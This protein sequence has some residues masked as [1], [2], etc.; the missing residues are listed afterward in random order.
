MYN[1][2]GIFYELCV[3]GGVEIL[4]DDKEDEKVNKNEGNVVESK[5]SSELNTENDEELLAGADTGSK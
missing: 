5:K 1:K 3:K 2:K 4:D